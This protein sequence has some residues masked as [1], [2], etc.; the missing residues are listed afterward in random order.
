MELEDLQLCKRFI[1]ARAIERWVKPQDLADF[2]NHPS[3]KLRREINHRYRDGL[4]GE[5]KRRFHEELVDV[6]MR[7]RFR[8]QLVKAP[9]MLV[10]ELTRD[11]R[12]PLLIEEEADRMVGWD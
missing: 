5:Q 3:D 4:Y 8:Y 1:Q 7:G 9:Q 2:E 11:F 10:D 12:V 6:Q